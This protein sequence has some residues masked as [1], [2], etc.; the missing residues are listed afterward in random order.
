MTISELLAT[1]YYRGNKSLLAEELDVNRAT[2]KLYSKDL[3]GEHHFVKIGKN[4]L[5]S[6]ELFTNQSNKVKK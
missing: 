3:K 4:K 6:G 2:I 5:F 1:T